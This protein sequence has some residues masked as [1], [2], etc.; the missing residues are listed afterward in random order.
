MVVFPLFSFSYTS[1]VMTCYLSCEADQLL[2]SKLGDRGNYLDQYRCLHL[3]CLRVCLSDGAASNIFF[4]FFK[5]SDAWRTQQL[6]WQA[7]VTLCKPN[8]TTTAITWPTIIGFDRGVVQEGE[9]ASHCVIMQKLV[10]IDKGAAVVG[11][12]WNVDLYPSSL[13][14]RMKL[15][16]FAPCL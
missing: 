16:R 12:D 10:I 2:Q 7:V 8:N 5:L 13:S 1:L 11:R 15:M 9:R 14:D 3:L 4:S 6:S